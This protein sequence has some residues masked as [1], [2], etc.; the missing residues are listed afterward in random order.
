VD[1]HGGIYGNPGLFVVDAS[2]LPAAVGAPPSLGI[3]AWAHHVADRL[4]ERLR[5][6]TRVPIGAEL[7]EE[8]R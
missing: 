8:V 2:A 1:H 3:A 5:H 6:G 7:M 4:A